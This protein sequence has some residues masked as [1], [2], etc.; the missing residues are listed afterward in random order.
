MRFLD[1]VAE[2]FEEAAQTRLAI[3]EGGKARF[4]GLELREGFLFKE[5]G[6]GVRIGVG[7]ELGWADEVTVLIGD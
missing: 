7:D 1:A 6:I 3:D 5:S 4:R 2:E